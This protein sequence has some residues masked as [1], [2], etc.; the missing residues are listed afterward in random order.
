[1]AAS[2]GE[3]TWGSGGEERAS[4]SGLGDAG[5]QDAVAVGVRVARCMARS[6]RG[7]G[8]SRAAARGKRGGRRRER[9]CGGSHLVVREGRGMGVRPAGP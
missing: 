5:G 8:A 6:A 9:G 2:I 1:M 4:V 3:R 7:A